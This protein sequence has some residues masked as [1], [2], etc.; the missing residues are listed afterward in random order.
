MLQDAMFPVEEVPAIG[1]YDN[2]AEIDSSG[3]KFIV[4]PDTGAVLSCMTDNYR[5][6]KN[7]T[8]IKAAEPIINKYKGKLKEVNVFGSGHSTHMSWHF[9]NHLVKIGKNDEMTPE[10]EQIF[11]DLGYDYKFDKNE[12]RYRSGI[13]GR[14]R[15]SGGGWGGWLGDS[16]PTPCQ[17]SP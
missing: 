14:L 17:N 15:F 10:L 13:G 16:Q 7:E 1:V 9:P 4:R 8:I 5:L 2:G 3:Y 12:E 11:T 6:V